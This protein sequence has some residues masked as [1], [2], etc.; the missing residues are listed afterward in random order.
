MDLGH[1][2]STKCMHVR[3]IPPSES[4][5]RL[6]VRNLATSKL[7]TGKKEWNYL[8]ARFAPIRGKA[9]FSISAIFGNFGDSGNFLAQSTLISILFP[10][11]SRTHVESPLP[12]DP[13]LT[14]AGEGSIPLRL[15]VA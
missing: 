15:N 11:G 9:G 1:V 7:A 13:L 2:P 4:F 5:A 14:S 12:L 6:F 3:R 8:A 10:S